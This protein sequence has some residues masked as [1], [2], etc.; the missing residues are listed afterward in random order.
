MPAGIAA[1][2]RIDGRSHARIGRG[3]DCRTVNG[4]EGPPRALLDRD[5]DAGRDRL[6][7]GPRGLAAPAAIQ[8]AMVSISLAVSLPSPGGISPARIRTS[9]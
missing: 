5:A 6:G 7:L 9:K 1:Q 2:E 4:L 8:R 3:R